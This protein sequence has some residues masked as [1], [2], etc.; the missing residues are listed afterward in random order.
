MS[1]RKN[2]C[3]FCDSFKI[4]GLL[5]ALLDLFS[6]QVQNFVKFV[7]LAIFAKFADFT[8]P[9]LAF[10]L[11]KSRIL[12]KL[13]FLLFLPY[14][15][16]SLFTQQEKFFLLLR[17]LRHLL[18]FFYTFMIAVFFKSFLL[19]LRK[20][21]AS[22]FLV[23]RSILEYP[24]C[25][26]S[27]IILSSLIRTRDLQVIYSHYVLNTSS[28][29]SMYQLFSLVHLNYLPGRF[30]LKWIRPR[31]PEVASPALVK[32]DS[33]DNKQHSTTPL[34]KDGFCLDY[35]AAIT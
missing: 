9:F 34:I 5:E 31:L 30:A 15:L 21:F 19:K 22:K 27:F 13:L 10:S 12:K 26:S 28:F 3:Y 1:S 18:Y 29:T 6:F 14:L 2:S 17:F 7:I 8:K 32:V 33:T 35:F 16:L 25:I 24:L 23:T 11:C 20:Q 4:C